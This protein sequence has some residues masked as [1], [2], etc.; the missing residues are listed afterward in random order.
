[1]YSGQKLNIVYYSLVKLHMKGLASL[2]P[3]S[4]HCGNST[5]ILAIASSVRMCVTN[6]KEKLETE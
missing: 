1:M 6:W 2:V 3:V 4:S 5:V